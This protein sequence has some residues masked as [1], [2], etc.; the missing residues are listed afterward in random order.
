MFSMV[1]QFQDAFITLLI[2]KWLG[3]QK[4]P[5]AF[6]P[7]RVRLRGCPLLER[8]GTARNPGVHD[9]VERRYIYSRDMLRSSLSLFDEQ[10]YGVNRIIQ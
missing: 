4:Y 3:L 6:D 9:P 8:Y 2:S 1:V 5:K 10:K 7:S